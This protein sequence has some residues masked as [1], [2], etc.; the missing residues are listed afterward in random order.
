MTRNSVEG[1][2][3][4]GVTLIGLFLILLFPDQMLASGKR[5]GFTQQELQVVLDRVERDRGD[6]LPEKLTAAK[7]RTCC[8]NW[9]L[10]V[11]GLM[12]MCCAAPVYAFAY[13]IQIILETMG[14]KTAVVL[15]LCARPYLLSMIWVYVVACSADRSHMRMPCIAV[16]AA[17]TV[18]GLLLR[19]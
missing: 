11:Y 13:F 2:L 6:T 3:T 1:A 15:L 12:F 8:L 19:G 18:T 4:I 10:W 16:N 7:I 9:E 17:I 14:F 5:H